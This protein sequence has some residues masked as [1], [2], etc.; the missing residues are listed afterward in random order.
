MNVVNVVEK[1]GEDGFLERSWVLPPDVVTPLRVH[2]EMTEEG[3]IVGEWPVTLEIA[4][5]VQPYVE[6]PIGVASGA[7]HIGSEQ[8][9]TGLL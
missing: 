6:E 7:W 2:I 9:P 3:W 4:A 8:V 5:I 1:F